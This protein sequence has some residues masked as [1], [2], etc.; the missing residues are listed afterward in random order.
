MNIWF[1]AD[2][3]FGHRGILKHCHRPWDTIEEM[4]DGLIE[5]WNEVVKPKDVVWH[6]GDFGWG[7]D[8][9]NWVL[10]LNGTINLLLG[11]HD[12]RH[13]KRLTELLPFVGDVRYLRH[14]G[15]RFWLSHYAHRTWRNSNHGSYHLFGHS[16][17]DLDPFRRSMDVGV[18]AMDY[19]PVNLDEVI[20]MLDRYAV[21][22]HHEL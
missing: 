4:N 11:N 13:K 17:G 20:R 8:I 10:R 5:N 16:H 12:D 7:P 22:D 14:E 18:D 6:L 21:T 2:T 15:E 1:T 9:D 19:H 3:H